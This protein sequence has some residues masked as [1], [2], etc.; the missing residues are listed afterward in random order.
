MRFTKYQQN[1][2]KKIASGE[3][4][5]IYS[6]LTTC[7]LVSLA[8]YNRNEI[9]HAFKD[10]DIPKEYYYPKKLPP[11]ISTIETPKEFAIKVE[12]GAINPDKY[13]KVSLNLNYNIGIKHLS[14]FD[15][16]YELD[17]YKGVYI[18]NSFNDIVTF[19]LIWQY[20][21]SE[22]LILDLPA[23][24]TAETLGLFYERNTR[25]DLAQLEN[26][27][28]RIKKINFADCSYDDGNYFNG[29]D[30]T[31]SIEHCT[32]CKEYLGRKLYPTPELNIFI[33]R[34][35]KTTE[36]KTQSS[37]LLAAWLA[38]FVAILLPIIQSFQKSDPEY[39]SDIITDIGEINT[40]LENSNDQSINFY[41]EL[42]TSLEEIK[43]QLESLDK[44]SDFSEI[45]S[46]VN[47]ILEE[48]DDT[49]TQNDVF[50]Q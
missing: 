25:T 38:I 3:I 40:Q 24:L 44:S 37:A 47:C 2:I 31:F 36:E 22:M 20:L 6:Y 26:L 46:K 16:D 35:F 10:D 28:E 34:N 42:T 33:Q 21:K 23:D 43:Q 15:I 39:F 13:D 4:Q 41:E 12:Q 7:N 48:I 8:Q 18:A 50:I 17:F 30:Y 1:I 32:I 5:D 11:K 19:L 45:V 49:L 29:I 9:E 14:W 27:S